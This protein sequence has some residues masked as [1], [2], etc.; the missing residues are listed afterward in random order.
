MSCFTLHCALYYFVF[1][2]EFFSRNISKQDVSFTQ[3][4]NYVV[5]ICC[6][7]NPP[8]PPQYLKNKRW[9]YLI[10]IGCY[11]ISTFKWPW[12]RKWI[13]NRIMKEHPD[14][15]PPDRDPLGRNPTTDKKLQK[16]IFFVMLQHI[17]FW[18]SLG[19]EAMTIVTIAGETS[20]SPFTSSILQSSSK[21]QGSFLWA[22]YFLIAIGKAG[23]HI[24]PPP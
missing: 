9:A 24:L 6:L 23:Q 21:T 7:E 1:S 17:W 5:E 16:K 4:N 14:R 2:C 3:V 15:D 20:N 13:L 10:L 19:N 8:P 11:L 18:L 12:P 22:Q